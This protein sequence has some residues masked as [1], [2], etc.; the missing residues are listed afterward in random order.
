[1]DRLLLALA[2]LV[3]AAVVVTVVPPVKRLVMPGSMAPAADGAYL[4]APDPSLDSEGLLGVPLDAIRAGAPVPPRFYAGLPDGLDAVPAGS[5]RKERFIAVMLP[6]ILEVNRRLRED[7]ARME[8]LLADLAQGQSLTSAERDWLLARAARAG[9]E[10][11]AVDQIDPAMLRRRVAPVPVSLALAQAAIESG[12]GASRFA[13]EGNAVYGQW[14]W[15]DEAP[16]IIPAQ[17]GEDSRHRIRAFD[18]LIDSVRGYAHNL[19][20]GHAYQD[21]RQR[22]AEGAGIEGLVQTMIRYSTRREAYVQD[23]LSVIRSNRLTDFDQA[24]LAPSVDT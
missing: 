22:R 24:R 12:W 19:N 14:T 7:R 9:L 13:Q 1:M 5:A 18:R 15:D 2:L 21:F 8:S 3:T 16:G 6:L 11:E 20:I 4:P 10:V 23:L 17:R